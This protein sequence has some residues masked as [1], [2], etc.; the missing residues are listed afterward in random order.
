MKRVFLLSIVV[1]AISINAKAEDQKVVDDL[2]KRAQSGDTTS[3]LFW[4]PEQRRVGFREITQIQPTR[5]IHRGSNIYELKEN[6]QDLSLIEYTVEGTTKTVQDFLDQ[7]ES[8][9]LI[10]VHRNQII[11]EQYQAG[12]TKESRWISFS[13]TKS[14]T[15]MLIGAA[16]KDGYIKSVDEPVV[17][18]LPR[19]RGTAYEAASIK[20]VLQMSSGVAW[21]EDY[22]DPDSDVAHAGGLNGLPLVQ[23]L[24]KLEVDQKPGEKFNYNTGETNLV[25]QILRAAIGNN[26]STYLTK[27]IWQPFGME[28]NASWSLDSPFGAELGG[29]C[30]NATLRDYARLGIFAMKN[31]KLPNGEEVLPANWMKDS[32]TPS[33][34]F[35]GYGYLWWLT[36]DGS[37]AAQGIFGQNISIDPETELVIAMHNSAPAAVGTKFHQER[38][39]VL[40]AIRAHFH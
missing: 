24:S 38:N 16:I 13:V 35:P 4:S 29:C 26:A 10:V 19:L 8:I 12:N 11:F 39:A 21:N 34:G 3:I 33:K 18:Y 30:I 25:G 22:A 5:E 31:G 6:S 20:D 2:I 7:P 1:A 27:K 14:V 36:G 40:A 32:T 23:Y 9:G 17:N 37:Y 28:F 15:S